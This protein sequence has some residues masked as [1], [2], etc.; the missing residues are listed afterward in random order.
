MIRRPDRPGRLRLGHGCCEQAP[1][2]RDGEWLEPH[3]LA[4]SDALRD[5]LLAWQ[6]FNEEYL[7]ETDHWDDPTSRAEF[8]RRGEDLHRRLEHELGDRVDLYLSA[9]RVGW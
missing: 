8:R 6:Q 9:E 1:L 5:D 2:W 3:E 4:L 7:L